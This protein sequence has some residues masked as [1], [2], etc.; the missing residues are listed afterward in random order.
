[1]AALGMSPFLRIVLG[2]SSR[3]IPHPIQLLQLEL[4]TMLGL[5]GRFLPVLTVEGTSNQGPKHG[6]R[7]RDRGKPGKG[8]VQSGS[9]ENDPGL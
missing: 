5:L 1:M 9:Y 6:K 2:H 4:L 3:K 8:G 7:E